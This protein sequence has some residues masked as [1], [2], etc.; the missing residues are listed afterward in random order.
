MAYASQHFYS[1]VT[2]R[3]GNSY[4][5]KLFNLFKGLRALIDG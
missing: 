4:L 2:H 3:I 5:N 1:V